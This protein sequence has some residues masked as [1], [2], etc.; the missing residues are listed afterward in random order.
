MWPFSPS[1]FH[2]LWPLL[3]FTYIWV[4]LFQSKAIL[5]WVNIFTSLFNSRDNHPSFVLSF[6]QCLDSLLSVNF[7]TVRV[8]S[9]F[10]WAVQPPVTAHVNPLI[11]LNSE[12]VIFKYESITA[13]FKLSCT[14]GKRH[15][16]LHYHHCM[17]L[18]EQDK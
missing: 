9:S 4:T 15:V 2:F 18:S 16:G 17:S 3:L 8:Y 10:P 11:L 1:T 12:W 7:E 14:L 5:I 6:L 13:H